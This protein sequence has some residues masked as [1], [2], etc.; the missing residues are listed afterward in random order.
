MVEV[1]YRPNIV[2]L[3]SFNQGQEPVKSSGTIGVSGKKVV[4]ST[5][6]KRS[7]AILSQLVAWT[8]IRMQQIIAKDTPLTMGIG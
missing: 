8:Q 2:D 6:H 5:D 1:V 7:D 3:G 4:L